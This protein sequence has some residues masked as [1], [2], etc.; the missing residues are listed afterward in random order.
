V[1]RGDLTGLLQTFWPI[2]SGFALASALQPYGPGVFMRGHDVERTFCQ[3]P[4]QAMSWRLV[5][6]L[7]GSEA[8][9]VPR[10][11]VAGADGHREFRCRPGGSGCRSGQADEGIIAHWR[12][13]FQR[14]V[15]SALNGPFDGMDHPFLEPRRRVGCSS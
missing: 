14:H 8:D 2:L 12:D 5:A 3:L 4:C 6:D 10:R 9:A 1:V 13:G 11:G 15:S 7:V